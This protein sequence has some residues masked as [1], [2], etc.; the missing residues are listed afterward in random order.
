MD[1]RAF[2]IHTAKVHLREKSM[3]SLFDALNDDH[4]DMDSAA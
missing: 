4:A 1:D 2:L 3:P